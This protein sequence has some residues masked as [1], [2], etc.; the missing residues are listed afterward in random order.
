MST[1]AAETTAP[2]AQASD[3]GFVPAIMMFTSFTSFTS[4]TVFAGTVRIGGRAIVRARQRAPAHFRS[5]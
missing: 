5:R 3:T 1:V 4:F 2:P